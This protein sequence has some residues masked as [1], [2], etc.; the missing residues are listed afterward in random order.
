M[1]SKS[2]QDIEN[3]NTYEFAEFVF[4]AENKVLFKD[5]ETITLPPKACELLWILIKNAGRVVLRDDLLEQVWADTFVEEA[6]LTHHISA[7][8]K[9]LGED[10]NGKRFIET[11]P[12]KGY[13]FVAPI[14]L[15]E[16]SV[17][18]ITISERVVER[19]AEEVEVEAMPEDFEALKNTVSPVAAN[20]I[21]S[22]NG[23]SFKKLAVAG[24]LL[25][26][27]CV[28]IG[29]A[30]YHLLNRAPHEFHA[31]RLS[32]LTSTGKT[33]FASVS[34]VGDLVAHVQQ[35]SDGNSLWVRQ[36]GAAGET[37]ILPQSKIDIRAVNFS[38]DGK[39]LYYITA[40]TSFFGTLYKIPA[41][42]GPPQKIA[43]DVYLANLGVNGIGFSPDGKKIAFV[44]LSPLPNDTSFL[45]IADADGG[46]ENAL[47]EYK[48]PNLLFGTPAWSP[49]GATIVCPFQSKNGMNAL[50]IRVAGE[51]SAAA[52]LPTDLN[53]VAQILWLPDGENLLMLAEDDTETVLS[54]IYQVTLKDGRRRRVNEDFNNYESIAL[55]HDGKT[56]AAVRTE[57]TAH[58]WTA[59]AD[60]LKNLRQLTDGFEKY[61]GV[62]GLGWLAN[63]KIFYESM[64]DGKQKILEVAAD[65][66]QA[67][68]VSAASGGYGAVSN[69]GR[70][71][72]YQ[73]SI[74]EG[75][76][77][78]QGLFL[79]DTI[80]ASERRLTDGWDLWA[81]F[82]PDN[83]TVN[84]IRWGE[85][86]A[87]ATLRSVTIAGGEPVGLTEF[88]AITAAASPDGKSIAVARWDGAKTQIVI[89]PAAGGE[90]S[91]T[92]DLNFAIQD[93][94]GKRAVQ[95]SAD[96]RFLN[97]I[98]DTNGVSNIWRQ[99]IDGGDPA[100]FTDLS[101]G[102]IYNFAFSPDGKQIALSRG[103]VNSDVV[104]LE[105]AR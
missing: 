78:K 38:P 66:T 13:R 82:L 76:R 35:S 59:P 83:R 98:R 16:N 34:P 8:R 23:I 64:P 22:K 15:Q 102:L 21:E 20:Q 55:T 1:I 31:G 88:L 100:Q 24:L 87:M 6:N 43:D 49:D 93:R 5:K 33:K 17:N 65:G 103:T 62:N 11:I 95:W 37:Q 28:S 104:L 86:E 46:N 7:L 54:Q 58:L 10:K 101:S 61:D 67:R 41:L 9:A 80:D 71:L 2:S 85:D 27:F 36:T 56:L 25:T 4:D 79:F 51:P 77:L 45:I 70:F 97:F 105:N 72:V 90:P 91:K 75:G 94:F 30:F 81:E 57:Q 14:N 32:R 84:F 92:F 68:Q 39:F 19:I 53:A 89:V 52:L 12:R 99:P 42:G 26:G 74:V 73:K 96:G 40:R 63:G 47:I 48:R 69:D 18:E 50:K 3:K 29:Y 44:R 60:D